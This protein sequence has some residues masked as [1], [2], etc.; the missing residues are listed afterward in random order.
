MSGPNMDELARRLEAE[1]IVELPV[2]EWADLSGRVEEVARHE[3]F[4]AGPLLLV[5]IAGQLAAVEQPSPATRVIR[6][7]AGTD[8]AHVF[9]RERLEIYDSMWNGCGCKVDYYH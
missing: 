8:E 9:V 2:A 3:T 7:L 4:I 6:R 5:R 1:H